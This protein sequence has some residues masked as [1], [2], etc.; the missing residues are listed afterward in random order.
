MTSADQVAR[1]LALVPYLQAHPDADLASTAAVFG[2]SPR[3]L[4]SDLRVL[5]FCGLPGGMP[6]D[7]IEIDMDGVEES[8]RVRLTNA[9]Y[10]TRPMRFT[11]D[12]AMSLIVALRAVGELADPALGGAAATALAK[13]EAAHGAAVSGRVGFEVSSGRADLRER[14]AEAIQ[15][16]QAVRLTYDGA[17]RAETTT[18][19]V[20]P[21]RLTV[22]DGY[23]YLEAWSLERDAWRT[24]RL[25][26]VTDVVV[27]GP[28]ATDRG[29]PPMVEGG[30]LEG[31]PDAALVRL[32]IAEAAR[33]ITEYYPIREC[34]RVSE[35][36][37][38]D[39]LVADPAWLRALLLRLGPHVLGVDPVEAGASAREAAR[40]TL[41][42]YAAVA[43]RQRAEPRW[44]AEPP[45]VVE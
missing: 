35:G 28:A 38:V 42:L 27:I 11:V 15:A 16:R 45:G 22:R 14:L 4:V 7:L 3:Q 39:L 26:R 40:E 5:W 12:E 10:L 36:W 18:P 37:E 25:D 8:G 6:G 43:G 1:L 41:R 9:D 33:W 13:L 29:E 24:Y 20:E 32:L 21:A 19:V 17:S 23:G 2:I 34:R 30:W 31:A 44:D